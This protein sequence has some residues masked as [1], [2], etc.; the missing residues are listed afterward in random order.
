MNV[1]VIVRSASERTA[2]YCC[3][4]LVN[5]TSL[6]RV[7]RV[8]SA[9]FW[10]TLKEGWQRGL[11]SGAE[12]ILSVDADVIPAPDVVARI[13]PLIEKANAR[14]GVITCMVQDKLFGGGRYQGIRIYRR[15]AIDDLLAVM[16]PKGSDVRPETAA[17]NRAVER[18]WVEQRV[19][20]LL[21]LHDYEQY[22]RDIYRKAFLHMQ[23]HCY[24][25]ARF[26]PA[27]KQ[28]AARDPD[29]RI[30][31][32]GAG[33]ALY[34]MTEVDCDTT[35]RAYRPDAALQRTGLTEKGGLQ[36]DV[37]RYREE[38]QAWQEAQD[39]GQIAP[40][41]VLEQ[42]A[43]DC[44]AQNDEIVL[45]IKRIGENMKLYAGISSETK[46]AALHQ[47]RRALPDSDLLGAFSINELIRHMLSR[48]L[49]AV[50]K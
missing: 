13:Q 33:D 37:M 26:L 18:G 43:C 19:P 28:Q 45:R 12:W 16:P 8:E 36:F 20:V 31:L 4:Q 32:A 38:V 22:Y 10:S 25:A 9:P 6:Q 49:N 3:A 24:I 1:H 35:H 7:E 29:F 46:S 39:A 23:K 2:A 5:Q 41:D 27:W 47:V 34:E 17:I 50:Q 42:F 30:A 21:G 48:F 14:V 44:G 15:I 11:L 40:I